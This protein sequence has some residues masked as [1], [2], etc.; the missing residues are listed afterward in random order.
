MFIYY[1]RD[2]ERG[3]PE[4]LIYPWNIKLNLKT[5][6]KISNE[7]QVSMENDAHHVA[8]TMH[9]ISCGKFVVSDNNGH[10]A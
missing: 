9:Y 10:L 5:E 8:C 6:A 7:F 4:I 3:L 2:Y 1:F